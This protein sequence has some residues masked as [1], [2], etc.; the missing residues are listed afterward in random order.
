MSS[1]GIRVLKILS[2]ELFSEVIN[3][4]LQ[5]PI[6][7]AYIATISAITADANLELWIQSS[8]DKTVW[9]PLYNSIDKKNAT[10]ELLQNV[11]IPCSPYTDGRGARAIKFKLS[12]AQGNEVL[13]EI[14]FTN[15][16]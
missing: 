6:A 5:S 3:I 1:A 13:L 11:A 4:P 14:G 7:L 2:G 12:E 15:I 9:F 10:L 8:I 16:T